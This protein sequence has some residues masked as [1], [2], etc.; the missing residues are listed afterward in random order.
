M[1][2]ATPALASAAKL[3]VLAAASAQV[4]RSLDLDTTLQAIVDAAREVT[5]ARYGALGIIGRDRRLS[6]FVTSGIDAA[7]IERIGHYPTGRGILGVL[8]DEAQPL[9]LADIAADPRSVGFPPGHPP[10]RSFLGVPVLADGRAFGNLYLTD[11]PG[12]EFEAEDEQLLQLLALHAGNAVVNARAHAALLRQTERAERAAGARD[13][14]VQLATTVL[15]ERDPARVMVAL[16]DS[17]RRLAHARVAAIAVPDENAGCLRYPV[18]SG[19]GAELMRGREVPIDRSVS[20]T[21]F[22]AA[23]PMRVDLGTSAPTADV[24]ELR[25]LGARSVLC[26]PMLAG[27]EPVAVMSAFDRVDGELFDEA[28]E[29]LLTS[30]AALGA[31]ALTTARAFGRERTRAEALATVR[32]HEADVEARSATLHRIL[33][34]QEHERRRIAQDLHDRTASALASVMF[35]LKRLER[36]AAG[37]QER[38]R[39]AEARDGL[40]AAIEDLRDLIA[41]LRP[42]VLDDF[43]LEP[44]LER[45]CETTERRSG[46]RMRFATD[47]NVE[48]IP[49]E[50]ATAAY[51]IAQEALANVVAHAVA[52]SA[53]VSVVADDEALTLL[54]EDDG[55]GLDVEAESDSAEG[56]YGIAG[57]RER[58]ALVGGRLAFES[59][60]GGG[61]RVRFEA[62]L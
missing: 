49:P 24:E 42:K 31:V 15:G 27:D 44:A 52:A 21:V 32:L 10:M 61:T 40:A 9:R 55:V 4:A 50:L 36:D 43:G 46:V 57:M 29:A 41:D 39:V 1:P 48:A 3:A 62:P 11:P 54:V 23:L 59:R 17:A 22:S 51:R 56:G 6:Q 33:E 12:G 5:G 20:G 28:D 26:V 53:N 25:R 14:V 58:S 2:A 19:Q 45:L 7:A 34:T 13:A 60:S 35:V 8:I 18:A 37:E 38:E 47:G 16:A 30:F